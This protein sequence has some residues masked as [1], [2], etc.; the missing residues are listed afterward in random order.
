M[1][2]D[3]RPPSE[4]QMGNGTLLA[5]FDQCGELEQIFAPHIDALQ[6]RLGSYQTSVVVPN[7]HPG[8]IPEL[9]PIG[10]DLFE[11]RTQLAVGSQILRIEYHHRHRPLKMKRTL[12]LHPSEP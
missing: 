2:W 11:V 6:S 10:Q 9:I 12:A 7:V 5:T 1:G 3:Q 4:I 8:D